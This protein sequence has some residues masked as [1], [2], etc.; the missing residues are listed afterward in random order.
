VAGERRLGGHDW[1]VL[2]C[3]LLFVLVLS[4][5][6]LWSGVENELE[7]GGIQRELAG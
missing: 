7:E 3:V 5:V 1:L 4:D 2:F 6:R